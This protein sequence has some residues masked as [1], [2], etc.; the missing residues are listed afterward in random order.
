VDI[1]LNK[2]P[3]YNP[4]CPYCKSKNI[5]YHGSQEQDECQWLEEHYCLNCYKWFCFIYPKED[6]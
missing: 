3:P 2:N 1:I 6:K 5:E 4:E